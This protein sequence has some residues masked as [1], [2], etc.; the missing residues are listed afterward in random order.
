MTRAA[1]FGVNGKPCLIRRGMPGGGPFHE[2]GNETGVAFFGVDGKPACIRGGMPEGKPASTSAETK[3]RGRAW[4]RRKALSEQRGL[5]G[6]EARFD[7][8]K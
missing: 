4:R 2:R 3:P 7:E 8:R 5:R 1:F 6:L